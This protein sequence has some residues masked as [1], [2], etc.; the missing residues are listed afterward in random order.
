MD[1]MPTLA[2]LAGAKVPD[3]RVIDGRDIWPVLS[4]QVGARSPHDRFFYY[5]DNQLQAVR[6][7]PW[8]LHLARK[9]PKG[10]VVPPSLYNLASD[11]GETTDVAAERPEVVERL[12]DYAAEFEKDLAA[13]SRPAAFVD[14]PKTLVPH[15]R[16]SK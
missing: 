16:K 3:D 2:K 11:L 8:K 13:H 1:L 9:G 15:R 4:G 6:S 12:S 10:K 5:R 14:D 7:G